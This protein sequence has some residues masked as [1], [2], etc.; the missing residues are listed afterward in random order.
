MGETDTFPS[1]AGE[2]AW[3]SVRQTANFQSNG[4]VTDVSSE[5]IRCYERTPGT[6]A[7]ATAAVKAGGKITFTA[8]PSIYHPGALSAYMAKAPAAAADF[9]G[10][11]NVWFKVFQDH[12]S[13][14]GGQYTWPSDGTCGDPFSCWIQALFVFP[15]VVGYGVVWCGIWCL[16]VSVQL[17]VADMFMRGD[18]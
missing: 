5:A 12:P 13:T 15:F 1:L 8:A 9:D 14:Q 10:A 2:G 11:G 3:E 18:R 6:A 4:P 16:N 17:C 7:P